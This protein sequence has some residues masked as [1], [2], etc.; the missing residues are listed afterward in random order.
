MKIELTHSNGAS[1][2]VSGFGARK[3]AR[4]WLQQQ[5]SQPVAVPDEGPK[6]IGVGAQAEMA[7]PRDYEYGEH[8]RYQDM[9]VVFGFVPNEANR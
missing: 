7:R 5:D 6:V 3:Y 4:T 9:P 2:S 8:S 1:L